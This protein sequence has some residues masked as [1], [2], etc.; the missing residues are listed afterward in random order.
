MASEIVKVVGRE[1]GEH[2]VRVKMSK[3]V[4][5]LPRHDGDLAHK[6]AA[7]INITWPTLLLKYTLRLFGS[8]GNN[9]S[10][11]LSGRLDVL[12]STVGSRL[13]EIE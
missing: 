6:L 11:K 10:N 9:N 8:R 2:M 5:V 12:L 13:I 1:F 7:G 4:R 3:L